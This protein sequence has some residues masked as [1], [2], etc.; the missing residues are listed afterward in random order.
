M[1]RTI[2]VKYRFAKDAEIVDRNSREIKEY[3]KTFQSEVIPE[4]EEIERR[5]T[6]AVEQAYKI[7][8]CGHF[9]VKTKVSNE[10]K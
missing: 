5:K 10:S 7:R 1:K 6:R 9:L 2:E 3:S 8:V 4:M